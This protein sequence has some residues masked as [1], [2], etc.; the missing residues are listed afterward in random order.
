MK[1]NNISILEAWEVV[2]DKIWILWFLFLIII[3]PAWM[4]V[5]FLLAYQESERQNGNQNFKNN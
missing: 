1:E 2:F 5:F 3:W 4:A